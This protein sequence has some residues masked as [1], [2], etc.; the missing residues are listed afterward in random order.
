VREES[1]LDPE[2]SQLFAQAQEA[3]RHIEE[4]RQQMAYHAS[5]RRD[6]IAALRLK[7]LSYREISQTLGCSRSAVQSIL[8]ST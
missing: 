4:A 3:V 1:A 6:A 5:Q 2:T 7:G 8:R